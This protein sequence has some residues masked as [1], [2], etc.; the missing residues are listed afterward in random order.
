MNM[1]NKTSMRDELQ[2]WRVRT[3]NVFLIIVAIAAGV[4]TII[5]V[6]DAVVRPGQWPTVILYSVLEIALIILAVFRKIDH[7]IR[8]WGVLILPYFVGV[9]TLA[10]YGLGSS[11]RLYLLAL[12]IGALILI[13]VRSALF[14]SALSALTMLVFSFLAGRGTLAQWL[15]ADRSSL[16]LADWVVEGGDTLGLLIVVM[17]LLILFNRFQQRLLEREQFSQNRIKHAQLLLEQQ[18][19]TLE[20]KVA[21]RTE[22][23]QKT[24]ASLE[25]RNA[26]LTILN[27][28]SEA[29]TQTLDIRLMT[30]LVGDHLR[31]IFDCDAV[32]IMLLDAQTNLIHSYYEYDRHEG[33]YIENVEPFPLGTGLTSQVITTRQPLLLSTLQEEIDH[34]AY[35]PPELLEKSEGNLTQSWLGVPILVSDRV[36]GVVFLGDYRPHAFHKNHLLLLQTI[37]PNIG[38]AIDNARLYQSEQQ[39]VAELAVINK[40]QEV[41]ASNLEIETIYELI[42]QQVREVFNVQVVDIVWYDPLTNIIS[43]PYSYEKGDRS[44]MPPRAPYGFRLRVI[45]T[46]EPLLINENFIGLAE[47]YNNPLITGEWPKSALFMPLIIEGR[48]SGVI[49]IQDL[50]REHAFS[51]LAVRLLQTL[52]NSMAVAIQ[53]ARLIEATQESQRRMADIIQFLPDATLVIDREGKVI[54]WNRA[55]EEMTGIRADDI[56]G[57]GNYAYSLPFYGERQPILIDLVDSPDEEL[58]QNY[59]LIG[60]QGSILLGEAIVPKLRGSQRYLQAAATNLHDSRGYRVGAIEIIRD[61]TEYKHAEAEL[62]ASEEKLRLI[63]ENAFD[64]ISIYEEIPAEDRRIL[65]DCNE[66]YCQMAGR[67]KADLMSIADTRT[68]QQSIENAPEAEDRAAVISE[69]VFSGVFSWIRPDGKEN[70]IEYNAAPTRVGERYFTIGLDRDITERRRAQ[71]ELRQA[72][73]MAEA[74]TQA[75]SAFLA[76]MS[77]ELR[78]PLNAIIG[79][80]RIVRRK[81]E[82]VLPEKQTENLDKVLVSADH[83][84]NL[85]NTVLDIAKIEAGRMDVLAANFRIAPLIDLCVNTTQPLIKPGVVLEKQVDENLNIVHS[86]QDK[87]RQIVLN[88]LSN[89]AKFTHVGRIL[90]SAYR[91]GEDTLCIAVSDTGIGISPEALPRIFKEFQQADSGTTR[92]YGGTGLGLSISRNL[93]HLLGGEITVQTELDKGSTFTLTL[94]LAYRAKI[95]PPSEVTES[96]PAQLPASPRIQPDYPML[97]EKKNKC[98]LVIDDDPDAVYL[99]R[100]NLSHWQFDIIGTRNGREG[101]EL[102]R[103]HQPQAILLDIVMPGADGWQILHDLKEDPLTSH[104]PVILLTIVDKKAL[105]FRLGASAYLLKPLDP[106]VVMD[107]LKRVIVPEKRRTRIL[108]VDDDPNIADMLRQF[109]PE[110][111]FSLDSA[112]DG[113]AGLAAVAANRPD[114]ILLDIVMPRLDGFGVIERLRSDP[115]TRSLPIIVISAKELTHEET[116]RLKASVNL[117]M[118]KQGLE[119]EKLVEEINRALDHPERHIP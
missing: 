111:R 90:I 109:I 60:R 119:G 81:A 3:L 83:L 48:V 97:A 39:R 8:A 37:C 64:G 72:K 20:Q 53:N 1:N 16:L 58:A 101:V 63:F 113:V 62:R 24:N 110:A 87:I 107:T 117:V 29:M 105:G 106:G 43:M 49:S 98:I 6:V 95:L 82:G 75:K 10:T 34:G 38:V 7:R 96:V 42:G 33:G 23:L 102:A 11:G 27:H 65:V 44:V 56:L 86:D 18:N 2:E 31:E 78:T 54:A 76:N 108:V 73:E 88:L 21:E 79:F 74:A 66:R 40:V 61:I 51:P 94:P 89:A 55:I 50:D 103:E 100:E 112:L 25:Q 116:Q 15:I 57:Q 93:A 70:I 47:K 69:Q 19:A 14:M 115:A 26:E 67:S 45:E 99:L 4:M 104:I 30:R 84:L 35:F 46:G 32:S 28:L 59:P 80:T 85:I 52:A 68:I 41:L 9:T 114:I 91:T 13:G 5:T 22:E 17:V 12:P 77:H 118:E 71:E 92:Q 36:L